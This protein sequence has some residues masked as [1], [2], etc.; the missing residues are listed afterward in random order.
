MKLQVLTIALGVAAGISLVSMPCRAQGFTI[1]SIA[2][3]TILGYAGDGNPATQAQVRPSCMTTDSAG[4]LY[5][6]DT[7]NNV[8]REVNTSGIISTLAGNGTLGYSGDGGPANAAQL[9]S[10]CGLAVDQNGDVFIA[11]TG[12]DV[13]REVT[14]GGNIVTAYGTN[15][16]GYAGDG[17]GANNAEFYSPT[18]LAIDIFGTLYVSD[19][20]NH[21]I[22][23]I[24]GD[25][26]T[27]IAGS[28]EPGYS[29]DGGPASAA[30]F[31]YPKGLA[32]DRFGQLYIADY[33]NSVIRKINVNTG[34]V[35]TAAGDGIP[36]FSGDGGPATSAQLAYPYDVAVDAADN[37]YI[38]DL[39]NQRVREVTLDGTITTIAGN[40]TR[41][42]SGDGGPAASA[43]LNNP[44]GVAIACPACLGVLIG[45]WDNN[46]VRALT[47]IVRSGSSDRVPHH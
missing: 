15:T 3:D 36:G 8:V 23:Q 16:R 29:G 46:V 34:I 41:G 33:G 6:A 17:G 47:P 38:A 31:Y 4:N 5:L 44:G 24:S 22:R 14:P 21:V 26:V 10:P 27:T 20:G 19:T 11:D 2:G 12:N 43:Q 7:I 42:Y 35:T 32:I 39:E 30:Q 1:S 45:D 25:I 18:G 28:V 9:A 40:G 13:I 37:L